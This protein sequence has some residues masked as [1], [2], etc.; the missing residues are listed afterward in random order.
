MI[1][2]DTP[3]CEWHWNQ[4]GLSDNLSLAV[5]HIPF[6]WDFNFQDKINQALDC[7]ETIIILCSELH[8][9]SAEFI[10]NN[11]HPKLHYFV[12]G[13]VA[14]RDQFSWMDWFITTV[15]AYKNSPVEL[16]P[17]TSKP[18]YFDALLG[19]AKPH[20]QIIYDRFKNDDRIIL[21]YL[22]DRSKSLIDSGWLPANNCT[23]PE[24]V[25]NTITKI[26]YQGNLVSLSQIIP[27]NV[28][29]Q[30]AYSIVA[31]TNY[32]NNYNFYTEK[33]AKPILAERLFVVFSGRNYLSG[34]RRLGFKTFDGII[35][36][37]YDSIED[38]IKR[39]NHALTQVEWLMNQP[40]EDILSKIKSIT[41]YNKNLMLTRD[42]LGETHSN[43]RNV[44]FN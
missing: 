27:D 32:A 40:Q 29:N 14:D 30:S 18:K 42:W 1:H 13:S 16:T 9:H 15:D 10:T 35:D 26:N 19:W 25:K 6:P 12:C 39:F 24:Q 22:R 41:E 11:T 31:E 8:K 7:Y 21:S 17:Y 2:L 20:R 3:V 34:L 38:P 23:V 4:L 43:I 36:E 44:I 28:Y 37:K 5:Y 33:I